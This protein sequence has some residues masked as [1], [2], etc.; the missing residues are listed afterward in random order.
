MVTVDGRKPKIVVRYE[1]GNEHKEVHILSNGAAAIATQLDDEDDPHLR[2]AERCRRSHGCLQALKRAACWSADL[3]RLS[4]AR[5]QELETK[6]GE[7]I[8]ELFVDNSHNIS[9]FPLS[10]VS[11]KPKLL[12]KPK[13]KDAPFGD[14]TLY[15]R[16]GMNAWQPTTRWVQRQLRI[17]DN[18]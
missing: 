12:P 7:L 18:S 13:S 16:G 5:S 15:V 11:S 1:N 4:K 14:E 10:K 3:H 17:R 6:D 2:M 9:A 8:A